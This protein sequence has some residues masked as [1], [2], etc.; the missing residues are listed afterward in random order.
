MANSRVCSIPDCGKRHRGLGYCDQHYKRFTRNGDPLYTRSGSRHAFIAKAAAY[1]GPDCLIWPYS[2]N[3][4]DGYAYFHHDNHVYR[5]GRYVCMLVHGEPPT[6]R[7]EAAHS[8]GKGHL[9]CV[10]GA[11]LSWKTTADN[12]RDR[13]EH[14]TSNRGSQ[15]PRAKL[16]E[17]DV[18]R[19]RQLLAA[20]AAP[21]VALMF[22]VSS[23]CIRDIQHK[24]RWRHV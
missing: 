14:G 15:N 6:S 3:R 4:D 20:H 1:K 19:I 2:R 18:T 9:G 16:T 11:H 24:R 17:N 22:N 23:V 7:H 21:A 8:C 5:A 10:S 12:Q 13:L